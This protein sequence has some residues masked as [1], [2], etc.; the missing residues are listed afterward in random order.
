MIAVETQRPF[1]SGEKWV[2]IG[3]YE[4]VYTLFRAE[5]EYDAARSKGQK[6]ALQVFTERAKKDQR[7]LKPTKSR[8]PKEPILPMWGFGTN[9]LKLA[10]KKLEAE[11]EKGL[12]KPDGLN[13]LCFTVYEFVSLVDETEMDYYVARRAARVVAETA[14]AASEKLADEVAKRTGLD[15]KTGKGKR[16][17][18]RQKAN[19]QRS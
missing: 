14:L 6:H 16:V 3:R 17:L 1:V 11:L 13:N 10:G 19:M 12:R 18:E 5:N 2:L 4:A 7:D 15:V 8:W 9:Y